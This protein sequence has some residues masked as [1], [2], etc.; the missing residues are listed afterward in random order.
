MFQDLLSLLGQLSEGFQC[1]VMSCG[2]IVPFKVIFGF[3]FFSPLLLSLISL[4]EDL[5]HSNYIHGM[6]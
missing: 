5:K 1:C 6:V 4:N 3:E 2:H